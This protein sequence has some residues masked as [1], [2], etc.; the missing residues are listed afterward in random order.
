MTTDNT[1]KVL[2]FQDADR[3]AQTF[4]AL[5]DVSRLRLLSILLQGEACVSD[6]AE[7]T[8][9]SQSAVSHQLKSLRE[10]NFVSTRRVGKQIY[11]RI[12]DD[13]IQDLFTRALE[14]GRH[15]NP[16]KGQN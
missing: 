11:Y 3:M 10:M 15:L 4:K 1:P 5:A 2:E 6:L 9:N 7:A 8:S 13:H 12:D 16:E 14:H